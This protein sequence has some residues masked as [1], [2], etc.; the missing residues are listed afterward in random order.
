MRTYVP[1][2][3]PTHLLSIPKDLRNI[4]GNT[5]KSPQVT[6]TNPL[7]YQKHATCTNTSFGIGSQCY[8]GNNVAMATVFHTVNTAVVVTRTVTSRHQSYWHS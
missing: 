7:G 8:H 1:T 5:R 6:A 4:R 3:P 2:V